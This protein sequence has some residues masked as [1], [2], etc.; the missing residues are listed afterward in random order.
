MCVLYRRR[1]ILTFKDAPP[2]PSERINKNIIAVDPLHRYSN[3][4]ET[5][6]WDIYDDFKL[7]KPFSLHGLYK[8]ISAL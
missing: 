5:A 2:P 7:E 4:A 3:E 8:H 6:N 1:E